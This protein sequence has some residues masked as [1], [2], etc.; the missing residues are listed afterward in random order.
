MSGGN[1]A[2][3][4]PVAYV[5]GR[6]SL[7]IDAMHAYHL[8]A[9]FFALPDRDLRIWAPGTGFKPTHRLETGTKLYSVS[10]RFDLGPRGVRIPRGESTELEV[11]LSHFGPEPIEVGT[12]W[13]LDWSAGNVSESIVTAIHER[14]AKHSF[15]DGHFYM[16]S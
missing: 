13:L 8:T 14:S 3:S 15:T 11:H 9:R 7:R 1:A 2:K 6:G 12:R 4:G 16:I 5:G 10:A